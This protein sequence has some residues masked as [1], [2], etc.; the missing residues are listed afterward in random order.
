MPRG[1]KLPKPKVTFREATK[2]KYASVKEAWDDF[3]PILARLI[4]KTMTRMEE[5]KKKKRAS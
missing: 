1:K 3:G 2:L 4:A 5:A